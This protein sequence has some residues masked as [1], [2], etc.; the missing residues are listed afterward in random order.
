MIWLDCE[1][2]AKNQCKEKE[3]NQHS[4]GFKELK[5]NDLYVR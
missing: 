2:F 5:N 1:L 4:S 3:Y